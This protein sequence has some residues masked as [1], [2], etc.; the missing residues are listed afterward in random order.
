MYE[1]VRYEKH[2]FGFTNEKYVY[3]LPSYLDAERFT[4]FHQPHYI[5]RA[6]QS[7]VDS[8]AR[9]VTSFA[10]KVGIEY[11]AHDLEEFTAEGNLSMIMCVL[12][13]I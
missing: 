6:M 8:L 3:T 2:T 1:T 5:L 4:Q 7:E 12:S 11:T 9:M 10:T 13:P